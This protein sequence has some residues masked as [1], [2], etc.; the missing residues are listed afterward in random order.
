MGGISFEQGE[1]PEPAG[2]PGVYLLPIELLRQYPPPW[3]IDD[4]PVRAWALHPERD[5]LL[6]LTT[7]HPESLAFL[8]DAYVEVD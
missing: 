5:D 7:E 6:Y 4:R 3:L 2:M 1:L 8:P